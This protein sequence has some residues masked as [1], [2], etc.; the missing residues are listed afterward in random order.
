MHVEGTLATDES[1]IAIEDGSEE[2]G[3]DDQTILLKPQL[4]LFTSWHSDSVYLVGIAL[5]DPLASVRRLYP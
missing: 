3:E 5:S 4:F 2:S 1:F